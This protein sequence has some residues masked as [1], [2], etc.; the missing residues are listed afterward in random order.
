M[1]ETKI[2]FGTTGT[3]TK[4]EISVCGKIGAENFEIK[5]RR[6][7][8]GKTWKIIG[9]RENAINKSHVICDCTTKEIKTDADAMK[10][11]ASGIS[12]FMGIPAETIVKEISKNWK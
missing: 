1:S 10:Y 12:V 4:K 2:T 3:G 7:E 9:Y 5:F 8:N 6:N 11:C